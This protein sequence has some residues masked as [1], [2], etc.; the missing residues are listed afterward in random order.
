[1]PELPD[2]EVFRRYL[3]S[4]GLH[5]RIDHVEIRDP[6][7]LEG[8]TAGELE[9]ALDGASLEE[10]RRRGKHL[11]AR[12]SRGQ[13]LTLHFGM[14]GFLKYYKKD[15]DEPEHSRVRLDFDNGYHLAYDCQRKLGRVG[16]TRSPEHLASD[17]DLG[18]DALDPDLSR[19]EFIDLFSGRRGSLKSGLM[20]Q[21]VIAGVGNVYSDEILFQLGLHPK[22]SLADMDEASLGEV[23]DAMRSVLQTVIEHGADPGKLPG[24]MLTAHRGLDHACPR[25]RGDLEKV[26]VSGRNAVFCPDCQTRPRG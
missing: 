6:G 2:V 11:M 17:E 19:Q 18:P 5:K 20:N 9:D 24:A 23:Y 12:I 25:C 16:L 13:W 8:V 14:T 21:Q 26:K 1:M 3:D 10:T 7:L 4:T 22:T 15:E